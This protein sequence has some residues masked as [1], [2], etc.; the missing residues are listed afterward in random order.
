ML[1]PG[2]REGRT[3]MFG[4]KHRRRQEI[5]AQPFPRSWATIIDRNVP[6]Y[7]RLSPADRLE[8]QRHIRV[9]LAEKRFEG[10]G[11]LTI[12][13]EIRVTVAAYACILLLH[14]ETDYYP[15]LVTVLVY[16]HTFTVQRYQQGPGGQLIESEQSLAGESWRHG[17]VV[18]A[19]D[20]VRHGAFDLHDGHNVVLHEFAHQLDEEDGSAN[21]APPLPRRSMYGPWARILG[22][23]YA[24]LVTSAE[25]GRPSLLDPY[26]AT[27]PAEFFSVATEFFFEA[28]DRLKA[29]HP[30]LYEELRLYYQQDPASQAGDCPQDGASGASNEQK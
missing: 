16:P 26:G 30:Q 7:R 4:I 9:F 13:D 1:M 23:D 12:T 20:E 6:Y 14:R 24:E 5:A 21:G 18:L 17:S 3:H 27:N 11:G 19:W 10:C 29:G 15:L 28:S 22:H 2:S 25:Q 8:L